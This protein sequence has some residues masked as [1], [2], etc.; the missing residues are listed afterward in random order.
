[1]TLKTLKSNP[2]FCILF[3]KHP[4]IIVQCLL[5][6]ILFSCNKEDEAEST[7][8]LLTFESIT[9]STAT[10]LSDEVNIT[11]KYYDSDGDLG[12]N[13]ESVK[14]LFVL[15]TRNNVE[16]SFRVQQLAPSNASISIEGSLSI[17]LGT[18]VI[19]NGSSSESAIFT[20]YMKDRA[21]NKSN[22]ISTSAITVVP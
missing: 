5:M 18:L 14:N 7:A 2:I 1:M 11:I 20:L 15:D 19:T 12:E 9:P 17:N 6:I 21:G 3:P 13:N 16:Y 8:P 10:E 4:M 22:T